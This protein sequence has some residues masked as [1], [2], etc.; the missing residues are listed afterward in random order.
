M[1]KTESR[2]AVRWRP[3]LTSGSLLSNAFLFAV[4]RGLSGQPGRD[5]GSQGKGLYDPRDTF[6]ESYPKFEFAGL[7]KMV[8]SLAGWLSRRRGRETAERPADETKTEAPA[9]T[10]P[11]LVS[12]SNPGQPARRSRRTAPPASSAR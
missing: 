6:E 8:L 10:G 9:I 11:T 3:G 2:N 4:T 7:V 12:Q 1:P 5:P